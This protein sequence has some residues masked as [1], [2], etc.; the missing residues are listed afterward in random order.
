MRLDIKNNASLAIC[1]IKSICKYTTYGNTDS[2]IY[3]NLPGCDSKYEIFL[4]CP[5]PDDLDG[6][7]V[8]NSIED[9]D[10]TDSNDGC[11]FLEANQDSNLISVLWEEAD[12]DNDG[13]LNGTELTNGSN[14]RNQDTD[15]DGVLDGVDANPIDPC[16]PLQ[17][18]DYVDYDAT[19]LT[20]QRSDCDGD[21]V[22]NGDELVAGTNP[23]YNEPFHADSEVP[24]SWAE[25]RIDFSGNSPR[26]IA[27]DGNIV[28]V[29]RFGSPSGL[30]KLY[31]KNL[32]GI[33]EEVQTLVPDSPNVRFGEAVALSG[34]TL[35]VG[36]PYK[37]ES[38]P[39]TVIIYEKGNDG[40]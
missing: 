1:N 8:L 12:C 33:W 28:A 19:S 29:G 9:T 6:D 2:F 27:I 13:I 17:D 30:V 23:Y 37:S 14:P 34:N 24:N 26:S 40:V 21:D 36:Q 4:R 3:N 18:S 39:D 7:G 10:G 31:E 38:A 20:W 35:F 11:S 5:N 15:G 25:Q 16:I 32:E 22:L